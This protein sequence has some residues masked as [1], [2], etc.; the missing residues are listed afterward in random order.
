MTPPAWAG[1]IARMVRW[2]RR[3][4]GIL[5]AALCLVA[6]LSAI[7]SPDED[8]CS[9][10]I[11]TRPLSSGLRIEADDITVAR[12][13]TILAVDVAL[14]EPPDAIGRLVAAPRPAGIILT[15]SDLVGNALV[16]DSA[17]LSL[18]P[19][20]IDDKTIVDIL[21]VGDAISVIATSPADE[22]QTIAHR[23]RVVA[24]PA[25][26]SSGILATEPANSGTAIIVAA[27]SKTA[28]RLAAAS[29]EHR[30]SIVLEGD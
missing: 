23:V 10:V 18:V 9:V 25:V 7:R 14:R 21:A 4:I 17:G 11:T 22:P 30:L 5:A 27:D 3:G 13:P 26:G 16:A 12:V 8:L 19:L 6:A 1:S 24:L 29:S 2:H 15:S 28:H 20:H